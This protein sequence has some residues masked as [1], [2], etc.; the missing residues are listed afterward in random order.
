MQK[1]LNYL[2]QNLEKHQLDA[3]AL[4]PGPKKPSHRAGFSF[5][6]TPGG[7][8]LLGRWRGANHFAGT[9]AG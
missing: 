9:G 6:G 1:R 2:I 4:N 3:V 7:G 8:G 5:D